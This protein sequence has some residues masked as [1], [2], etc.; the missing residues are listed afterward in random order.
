MPSTPIP[1]FYLKAFD[2]KAAWDNFEKTTWLTL[3][4]VTTLIGFGN[5]LKFRH[6][7]KLH[8]ANHVIKLKL[9][10]A[11]VE[12]ASG[13]LG[14]IL[15]FV[16]ECDPGAEKNNN[17][18]KTFCQHLRDFL[19]L[20]DIATLSV[21][22]IDN[23]LRTQARKTRDVGYELIE[24]TKDTNKQNKINKIV[25]DLD[26]FA[27][28]KIRSLN[29]GDDIANSADDFV[30]VT[31]IPKITSKVKK[32]YNFKSFDIVVVDRNNKEFVKLFN[33]WKDN[34]IVEGVFFRKNNRYNRYR[35]NVKGPRI[36]LFKG[37]TV[38]GVFNIKKH[39]LQHE[40][41]HVE[42][43]GHLIKKLGI[44]K[45]NKIVDKIPTY[46]K[47]EYVVHRFL[48]TKTKALNK[49]E[50]RTE[51]NNIN[52]KYRKEAGLP[53]LTKEYLDKSWTLKNEL[54]KVNIKY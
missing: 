22:G 18:K 50:F 37:D 43:H 52:L 40:I 51:L 49:A 19:I 28:E 39:T 53:P 10:L 44:E 17:G 54:R 42:M 36:Y 41:F 33:A 48:K 14:T 24:K 26:E 12:V 47:E 23:L 15:N 4:A 5:L 11:T 20:L 32:L 21:D 45:Y 2:D 25:D 8:K 6:L 29:I 34:P 38:E 1:A 31:E 13:A 16:N 7:L 46:I 3:D 9:G 30:D 35:L 27:D